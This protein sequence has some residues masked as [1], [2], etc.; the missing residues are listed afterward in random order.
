MERNGLHRAS[1]SL[2]SILCAL[3]VCSIPGT[4]TANPAQPL[5][6]AGLSPLLSCRA[7]SDGQARLICFDRETEKLEAQTTRRDLVILDRDQ[8]AKA[9]KD[10]FG[11]SSAP[12]PMPAT[13]N[14]SDTKAPDFIEDRLQS[15][16]LSAD[17]KWVF[18]LTNGAV[19]GQTELKGI[20][21]PKVGDAIRIRKG[22]L[23]SFLASI[24]DRPAIRVKRIR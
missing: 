15:A 22:A 1:F 24:K 14:E 12:N 13:S 9:Q 21:S 18:T 16:R 4:A 19:W 10:Q 17:G 8:I 7:L 5:S 2:V 3:G 6:S 11:R 23:G 20:R